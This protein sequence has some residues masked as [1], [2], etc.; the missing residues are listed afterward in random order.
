[1]IYEAILV[2]TLVSLQSDNSIATVSKAFPV[3]TT[4]E[5]IVRKERLRIRTDSLWSFARCYPN[6]YQVT[7]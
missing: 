1:M 6:P 3:Q 5:C 2:M 4:E 7:P